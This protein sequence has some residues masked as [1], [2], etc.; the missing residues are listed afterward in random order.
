VFVRRWVHCQGSAFCNTIRTDF[1]AMEKID[2]EC[3]TFRQIKPFAAKLRPPAGRQI[4]C[5][6]Y[7]G[8]AG[9]KGVYLA[10]SPCELMMDRLNT[11]SLLLRT[12]VGCFAVYSYLRDYPNHSNYALRNPTV[13]GV[14][15]H[16][17]CIYIF[18]ARMNNAHPAFP[19][20]SLFRCFE[21]PPHILTKSCLSGSCLWL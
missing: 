10:Y 8:K 13:G 12:L 18:Y 2:S 20:E 17:M 15:T 16:V 14:S 9:P 4:G 6:L 21:I 11:H 3:V 7:G 5:N 19:Q 1:I